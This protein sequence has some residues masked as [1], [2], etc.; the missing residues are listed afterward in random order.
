MDNLPSRAAVNNALNTWWSLSADPNPCSHNG[1]PDRGRPEQHHQPR[2]HR[3]PRDSLQQLLQQPPHGGQPPDSLGQL[4]EEHPQHHHHHHPD[5]QQP[6]SSERLEEHPQYHHHHPDGQQ[7]DSL[8]RLEEHPPLPSPCRDEDADE[9]VQRDLLIVSNSFFVDT[10][11]EGQSFAVASPSYPALEGCYAVDM[12]LG[13]VPPVV[14]QYVY[15]SP[16]LEGVGA[17]DEGGREHVGG[18]DAVR[19]NVVA[20]TAFFDPSFVEDVSDWFLFF[21]RRRMPFFREGCGVRLM[22]WRQPLTLKTSYLSEEYICTKCQVYT[23]SNQ[24]LIWLV[25]LG[26]IYV[27][28][29]CLSQTLMTM[30]PRKII[31]PQPKTTG[32]EKCLGPKEFYRYTSK[33]IIVR[34]SPT[35]KKADPRIRADLLQYVW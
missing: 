8:E 10:C 4:E 26:N 22:F 6:D 24:D 1:Q 14:G 33:Y 32:L 21:L 12:V 13:Q 27:S 16:R 19:E 7:P 30:V 28:F 31:P 3:Q 15:T 5:G 25:K 9:D 17:R 20:T 23:N 2:D 29:L 35:D 11:F 18:G 34:V